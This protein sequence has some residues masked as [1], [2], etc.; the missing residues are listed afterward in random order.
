MIDMSNN[1]VGDILCHYG[2]HL[3]K[4][5]SIF[6]SFT[7]FSYGNQKFCNVVNEDKDDLRKLILL[8]ISKNVKTYAQVKKILNELIYKGKMHSDC[9]TTDALV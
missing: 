5:K 2:R 7:G 4:R 1:D 6:T 9:K 8:C 3:T